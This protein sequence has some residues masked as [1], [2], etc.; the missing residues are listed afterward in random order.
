MKLCLIVDDSEIIRKYTRLIFE[1]MDYRAIEAEST[2]EA[3]DRLAG[4]T[5]HIILVDWNIPGA[6]MHKFIADLRRKNLARRPFIIYMPTENDAE[7]IT[8][9]LSAGA[10]DYLLKPFNRD[11]VQMKLQEVKIAA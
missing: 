1:S 10:D 3:F 2:K 9:A 4:E 8:R 7:D 6:D 11:I 5:P